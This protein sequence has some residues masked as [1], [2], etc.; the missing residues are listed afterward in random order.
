MYPPPPP[1]APA[2]APFTDVADT[3]WAGITVRVAWLLLA[4]NLTLDLLPDVRDHVLFCLPPDMSAAAAEDRAE[5]LTRQ[6]IARVRSQTVPNPWPADWDIVPS[7]RWRARVYASLGGIATD[8]FAAHYANELDLRKTANRLQE[9]LLAVEAACEGFREV[10]RQAAQEDGFPLEGWSDNR[11]DHMLHRIAALGHPEAPPLAEVLAG[12]HPDMTRRCPRCRRAEILGQR[13][14][15]QVQQLLIPPGGARPHDTTQ[16]LALHLHPDARAF[17]DKLRTEFHGVRVPVGE[18][19]LLVPLHD[20]P[21]VRATLELAAQLSYP[22]RDHLRGVVL[23]GPGRWCRS[24]LLGP[25]H[26]R[27]EHAFRSVPWGQIDGLGELPE[28]LAPAPTSRPA[29]AVAVAAT[30]LAVASLQLAL[31]PFDPVAT[32]PLEVAWTE[33]RGGL[34][35]DFDVDDAAHIVVIQQSGGQLEV[36][37]PGDHPADK[38]RVAVGD[39]RYRF[40]GVAD[41]LL[42]AST[43]GAVADLPTLLERAQGASDPLA[44]LAGEIKAADRRADVSAHRL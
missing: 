17:R 36:V 27:A 7:P 43:A 37:L 11:L 38:A 44:A 2:P 3:A 6:F 21:A 26:E 40:H 24:G 14:Y 30:V 13:G 1:P 25:L 29:W 16:V 20:P 8:V 10:L 12:R 34:W 28:P 42:I 15:L 5:L 41:G 33:A 32:Y 4:K 35:V 23:E 39:G 22:P 18:D 31:H 19:I 9:D